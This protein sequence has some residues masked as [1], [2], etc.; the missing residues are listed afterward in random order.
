MGKTV[1]GSDNTELNKHTRLTPYLSP[2]SVWALSFG[3]AVGW[4]SFVMP[5][6]T[7]LPQAGPIG[8]ALGLLIGAAVI[9]I[10]GVNYHY[11]MNRYPDAGG[12]LTYTI[13]SFGYDHGILSAWFLMLV[14][15]AII[16]ANAT[17]LAL[18]G[19]N[20]FGNLFQFGFHYQVLGYDVYF[21]ET[22]L[23]LVEIL[24]CGTLAIVGKRLTV[25]LQVILAL[26]LFLGIV[27]CAVLVFSRIGASLSDLAPLYSTTE[28][29]KI[30]QIFSIVALSPWAFAGF[31]S[32]SNS[33]EGFRFSVKHTL[34]IF[35]VS[36]L[37]GVSVYVLL[38]L[39]AARLQ[40]KG[41][42][43]WTG[44]IRSIG[45]L[46]GIEGL[47]TFHTVG[48]VLGD[49]GI[50]VMAV[51]ATA[52]IL[53]GLIGNF[54]AASRLLYAMSEEDMLPKWFGE[55][56]TDATP[57][58]ALVFLMLLSLPIPFLGRTAIGWIV[59]VNTV[60]ATIAYGYTSA[61]AIRCAKQEK[62]KAY[63]ISGVAGL[64]VSVFFFF[65]FMAWSAEA[66][67]TE[68][69]L[70]LA[71]WSTLGFLYFRQVFRYDRKKH[72]GKSTVVL[73]GLLFLIF[74]TS[75]MWVKK[76]TD[77]ATHTVVENISDYYKEQSAD[78]D[79]EMVAQTQRY[80]NAQL[81]AV[82][83]VLARNSMIQMAIIVASLGIMFSIYSTISKR[84]RESEIEKVAAQERERAKS[85]FLSNMSHDI[86]TP[87]NAILGYTELAAQED[88]DLKTAKDYLD[89]IGESGHYLQELLSD[90][91]EMSHIESGKFVLEPVATDLPKATADMCELFEARMLEKR[92]DFLVDVSD[93]RHAGVLCDR[94]RYKR[95]LSNLISNAC[96]YTKEGGRVSVRL[97]ELSGGTETPVDPEIAGSVEKRDKTG[98]MQK[99]TDSNGGCARYELHVK[100]TGIGMSKEFAEHIFE[101]F[102]RERNS[103][104][105]GIQGT[106]LGMAITKSIV[107]LMG[108]RI[109]VI[110]EEGKGSEF[111][112]LLSFPIRESTET[113]S[114][115]SAGEEPKEDHVKDG[116]TEA[117]KKQRLLIAEDVA[118]NREIIRKMLEQ[119]GYQ[120]DQAEN[121]QEAVEKF[122]AAEAG[123]YDGILMDV[124]M[125]ELNGYEAAEAIRNLPDEK[126]AKIPIIAMTANAFAEDVK[127][128]ID[129]G[130]DA[131][132]AKP[133]DPNRLRQVLENRLS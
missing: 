90:V 77:E 115:E 91:L 132:I 1:N 9:W 105:S 116:S 98:A 94:T 31:E 28:G 110:S 55:L 129:A 26:I 6:T 11:L 75:L 54:I 4:G 51:A 87:M 30:K 68:S 86:R 84:E 114:A 41:F 47:P 106:G 24:L 36:L 119:L 49:G 131:H 65:Y 82:S 32:V 89:K 8:T 97:R 133:I 113:D 80:I 99:Q 27:S 10:I 121:G 37:T 81:G 25:G 120:T 63:L 74:F 72:F 88:I 29:G 42:A 7:F 104:V 48:S 83:R 78:A 52:A 112:V 100:D 46:G 53:T 60:G 92:I 44:Y 21:G 18:I 35:T 101:P 16:W 40:P 102:E 17:A 103:T 19:R 12:T 34:K 70:I 126:G 123:Y 66:M 79:P 109:E 50:I 43:S 67:S 59:D 130:M 45:E 118:I 3:C 93:V 122:A 127:K 33:T 108:G 62:K 56:G 38:A 57:K 64:V 20:L 71:T 76:A 2:L 39:L 14:Y 107:D 96:K 117:A 128:A 13:R 23:A 125:P 5:G 111:I 73:I 61:D 95:V 15:I 22:L 124:Q 58:N 85:V 69:Y